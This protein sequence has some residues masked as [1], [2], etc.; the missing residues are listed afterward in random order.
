M[1]ALKDVSAGCKAVDQDSSK[2]Y[3]KEDYFTEKKY[4]AEEIAAQQETKKVILKEALSV[5][6]DVLKK[7]IPSK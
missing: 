4:T 7:I 1:D 2:D 5:L 3:R 6:P